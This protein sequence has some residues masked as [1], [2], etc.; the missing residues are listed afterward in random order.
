M[1]RTAAGHA[2]LSRRDDFVFWRLDF[3][4]SRRTF[5]IE[6]EFGRF[7][8]RGFTS[9]NASIVPWLDCYIKLA[10]IQDGGFLFPAP[11]NP[12][13]AVP[14]SCFNLD[15]ESQGHLC[16]A[17][18]VQA[19]AVLQGRKNVYYWLNIDEYSC[20]DELYCADRFGFTPIEACARA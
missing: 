7:R 13:E 16:A 8:D 6:L 12:L 17:W 4:W 19:T 3:E 11:S 20:I 15:G 5:K 10:G 14:P 9:I 2:T 1:H 18:P